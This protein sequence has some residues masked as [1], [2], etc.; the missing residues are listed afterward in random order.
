MAPSL[1]AIRATFVCLS[2]NLTL[3]NVFNGRY[4][5]A[6]TLPPPASSN[7]ANANSREGESAESAGFVLPSSTRICDADEMIIGAEGLLPSLKE[8]SWNPC[9]CSWEVDLIAS[10]PAQQMTAPHRR[11][12]LQDRKCLPPL[13]RKGT[14]L[15]K[16]LSPPPP[17]ALPPPA[18]DPAS[19]G[20]G[21]KLLL[22]GADLC[23]LMRLDGVGGE[24]RAVGG[25]AGGGA[26]NSEEKGAAERREGTGNALSGRRGGRGGKSTED[27]DAAKVKRTLV[28]EKSREE[29]KEERLRQT[30]QQEGRKAEASKQS[31]GGLRSTMEQRERKPE[32]D[33]KQSEKG[34]EETKEERLRRIMRQQERKAEADSQHSQKRARQGPGGGAHG[35][36]VD[37][38]HQLALG[39]AFSALRQGSYSE[40]AKEFNK[41]EAVDHPDVRQHM[42]LGRGIAF[43]FLGQPDKA[44]KDLTK[45]TKHFPHM[46]EFWRRRAQVL[47]SMGRRA[48]AIS[49]YTQA[50]QLEPNHYETVQERGVLAFQ[51][52]DFWTAIDDLTAA[53]KRQPNEPMLTRAVALSYGG[54]GQWRDTVNIL[55][56]AVRRQPGVALLW[57]EKG[58]AHKELGEP[59]Q[60]LAALRKA[61]ALEE[62]AEAYLRLAVLLQSIGDHRAAI[63]YAHKG[64]KLKPMDI[65]LN[66]AEASSLHAVGDYRAAI[67]QYSLILTLPSQAA[68][69]YAQVQQ[70][71]A[72]YQRDIATYTWS[73]LSRPFDDFQID[74]DLDVS[75]KE[76]WIRRL[77]PAVLP[78]TY[79]PLDLPPGAK[80]KGK[81]PALPSL[82][83]EA[84]DLIARADEIGRRA[85]YFM[86]GFMPNKRQFRMAG[87]AALDV[88][89]QV[90]ATW[91]GMARKEEAAGVEEAGKNV[92][93]GTD[94]SGEEGRR[95]EE[96]ESEANTGLAQSRPRASKRG[97]RR[98]RAF[99]DSFYKLTRAE[100]S[101]GEK[102][103]QGG[104]K[105]RSDKKGGGRLMAGWRDMFNLIVPW[106]QMGEP[107]DL[108]AWVDLLENEIERGYGSLTGI[109]IGQLQNVKYYPLRDRTLEVVKQ[110]LLESEEA[111]NATGMTLSSKSVHGLMGASL[112]DKFRIPRNIYGERIEQAGTVQELHEVVGCDFFINSQCFSEAIPGKALLGTEF[113]IVSSARSFDFVIRTTVDKHRWKDLDLELTAAW[114]ALCE[115]VLDARTEAADPHLY[116]QRIQRSILRLGYFWYQF[117]PLTRG[118][119]MV[120]LISIL[121]LSLAADMETTA[122]I[123]EGVQVDWEALLS[124]TFAKFNDSVAPWLYEHV[125]PAPWDLPRV[126]DALPTTHHVVSAL[127]QGY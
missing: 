105:G 120:G 29:A 115:S 117:M 99:A 106:R 98:R 8:H 35:M 57:N 114:E 26:G 61:L 55:E 97:R 104:L 59:E 85:H 17:S 50:L 49:D 116:R 109:Q 94:E 124:P 28:Q 89:Q 93:G 18:C 19:P 125:K 112:G 92:A 90:R 83:E 22:G 123:P 103:A 5:T 84:L 2:L 63:K 76:A 12:R 118:S 110:R 4:Y 66:Y 91:E 40:A 111:S 30:M 80:G 47:S 73:K 81:S 20:R 6:P 75:L 64:L 13:V 23:A 41:L 14:R 58:R 7:I 36:G 56:E 72:F 37:P 45:G 11:Q 82:S 15:F 78:P 43:T 10:V 21:G 87:L 53:L 100:G 62:T 79:R 51:A 42:L 102:G 71:L 88:M 44:L 86:D 119:A 96:D 46:V 107:T 127:S 108:V 77:P 113:S 24:A 39:R 27:G 101:K 95:D 60:A 48:E 54:A 69:E 74:R 65:E 52:G 67:S 70:S 9:L 31:A 68:T 32:E 38:V 25:G 1:R 33:R 126:R 121:G 16:L 3:C 122:L 34:K